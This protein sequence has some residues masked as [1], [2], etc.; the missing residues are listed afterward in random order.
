[1]GYIGLTTM[2]VLRALA[3]LVI[4]ILPSAAATFGTVVP[5]LRPLA[6]LV[7]DEARN[8]LYV[9][10]TQDNTVEVYS[11]TT[12]PPRL[13]N[14]IKVDSTPL[15]VSISRSGRSLYVACF[16]ASS[17]E[18][19]DLTTNAFSTHSVTLAAKP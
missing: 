8:R 17:L 9:A 6:D 14:T 4:T 10:N 16:D 11:T 5:H 3:V 15:S 2:S 18:I 19:V 12:S 13:T 7:L 1:M